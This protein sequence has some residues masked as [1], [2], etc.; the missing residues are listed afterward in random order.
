M[1]SSVASLDSD[2]NSEKEN[3]DGRCGRENAINDASITQKYADDDLASKKRKS[4]SE[5]ADELTAYDQFASGSVLDSSWQTGSDSLSSESTCVSEHPSNSSFG[6]QNT[7]DVLETHVNSRSITPKQLEQFIKR[8]EMYKNPF[9]VNVPVEGGG[10]SP[11]LRRISEETDRSQMEEDYDK[12]S[13][14]ELE[15]EASSRLRDLI[16]NK[17]NEEIHEIESTI[18]IRSP[19][20]E[21][22]HDFVPTTEHINFHPNPEVFIKED[23]VE[24]RGEYPEYLYHVAKGKDGRLYLRV[25]RSLLVDKGKLLTSR[26]HGV[27][28]CLR[29]GMQFL[30][31]S[32]FLYESIRNLTKN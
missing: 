3:D 5:F 20:N 19:L 18:P 31:R 30:P 26:K 12:P 24:Q 6:F 17:G 13:F 21:L 7:F 10:R 2:I 4:R 32:E 16:V 9:F 25:V 27:A 11:F 1:A 8:N 15:L 29:A 22:L 28:S 23:K 14:F